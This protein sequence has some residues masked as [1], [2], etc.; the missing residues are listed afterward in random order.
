MITWFRAKT[1]LE[2][3]RGPRRS[4]RLA[5]HVQSGWIVTAHIRAEARARVRACKRI[6]ASTL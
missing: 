6:K 3:K 1:R 5:R 4:S 2:T